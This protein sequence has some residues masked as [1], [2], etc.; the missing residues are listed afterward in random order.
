ML[1]FLVLLTLVAVLI[2]VVVMVKR[3]AATKQKRDTAVEDDPYYNTA[4]VMQE[5]EMTEQGMGSDYHYARNHTGE[6][7]DPFNDG[8]NP[9][10]VVD[11]KAHSKS[12]MTPVP[13][14]SS[15]PTSATNGTA[16][17]IAVGKCKEKGPKE[18]GDVFSITHKEDQYAMPIK[19]EG[20]L[21]DKGEAVVRSGGTEE[22]ELYDAMVGQKP[23]ADSCESWQSS[24]ASF[25]H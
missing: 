16:V 8:F 7:E 17:Y 10:E 3:K 15:T 25:K 19:K 13:K 23:W 22:E 18:T 12:T 20:K 1:L 5:T 21:T 6:E 24:A 4:I 2:L 9:Y 11:R 14:E